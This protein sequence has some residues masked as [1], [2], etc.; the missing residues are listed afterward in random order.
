[1]MRN[2][3]KEQNG[4]GFTSLFFCWLMRCEVKMESGMFF[5]AL[6]GWMNYQGQVKS[7]IFIANFT[8]SAPNKYY[9]ITK[10][11]LYTRQGRKQETI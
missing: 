8:Y 11:F 4:C 7:F 9:S 1:M 6:K 10:T 5:K 3:D 2:E